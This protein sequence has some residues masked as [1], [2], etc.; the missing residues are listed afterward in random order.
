MENYS[1]VIRSELTP[2]G[3]FSLTPL[4]G[5]AEASRNKAKAN[6]HIPSPNVR[7][8]VAGIAHVVNNDPDQAD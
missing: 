8:W 1:G 2:L 4:R 5:E 7:D 6:H 3:R